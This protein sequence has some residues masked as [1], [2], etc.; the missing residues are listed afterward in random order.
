MQLPPSPAAATF[1]FMDPIINMDD[2]IGKTVGRRKQSA[3]LR[4]LQEEKMSSKQWCRA[5]FGVAVPKG[6][7]RFTSHEEADQWLMDHLTRI[8][9]S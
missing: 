9:V 8:R 1:H 3:P 7:Y 4:I 6:V 2:P 5:G